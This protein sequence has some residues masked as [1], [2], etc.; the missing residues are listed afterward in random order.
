MAKFSDSESHILSLFKPQ[1]HFCFQEKNWKVLFSGK[2]TSTAGEPKTDIFVR[3]KNIDTSEILDLKIS[4][5]QADA[6]FLEN[7]ISAE[8][9]V[10]ILGNDWSNIIKKGI[11]PIKEKFCDKKLVYKKK[12]GN[13]DAGS[14]TLG[15]KFE[16][17]K[18]TRNGDCSG[19]IP[20]SVSQKKSSK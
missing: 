14:I 19:V 13:I 20:L 3:C 12:F 1:K 15:W 17:V 10:Q 8:R 5:K 11:A 18:G 2:P 6:E 9:A 4:Y 7:K 16:F